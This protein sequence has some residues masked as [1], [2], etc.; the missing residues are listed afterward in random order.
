MP[1]EQPPRLGTL[2]KPWHRGKKKTV[3]WSKVTLPRRAR[4]AF[5]RI[6]V[7]V[8]GRRAGGQGAGKRLQSDLIQ[9]IQGISLFKYTSFMGK[10]EVSVF[11]KDAYRLQ[12]LGFKPQ[13]LSP[14][15]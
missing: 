11:L 9:S 10:L 13:S 12:T 15:S 5:F 1:S 3:T 14:G 2:V 6:D 7:A 8:D 4:L